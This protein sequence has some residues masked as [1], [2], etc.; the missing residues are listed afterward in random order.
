MICTSAAVSE[1]SVNVHHPTL[2]ALVRGCPVT[3]EK[4]LSSE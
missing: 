1:E 4:Q 2:H 3:G